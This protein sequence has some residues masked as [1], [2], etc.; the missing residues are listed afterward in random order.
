M[1]KDRGRGRG[2]S[3]GGSRSGGGASRGRGQKNFS[4]PEDG[5]FVEVISTS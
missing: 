1:K 2:G 3:R 5:G 4:N